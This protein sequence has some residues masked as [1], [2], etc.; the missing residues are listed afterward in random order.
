MRLFVAIDLPAGVRD[1]AE[2]IQRTL[3]PAARGLKW[4]SAHNFHLTVKFLG[5]VEP[6]HLAAVQH[7]LTG[8]ARASEPFS[9]ELEGLGAFPNLRRPRVVWLGVQ[10]Q[11]DSLQQLV[12]RVDKSLRPLGFEPE[13]GRFTAH[14]TLARARQPVPAPELEKALLAGSTVQAGTFSVGELRLMR[15]SLGGPEP[16]YEVVSCHALGL[17]KA[18][19]ATTE[20]QETEVSTHGQA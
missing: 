9:L 6:D 20:I 13:K 19:V 12:K 16:I 10:G 7:E 8:C 4:V 3:R 2:E 17:R 14:L 18:F 15:S 11:V 1:R 5:E